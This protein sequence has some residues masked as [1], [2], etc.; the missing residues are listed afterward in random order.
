MGTGNANRGGGLDRPEAAQVTRLN[1]AQADEIAKSLDAMSMISIDIP[2]FESVRANYAKALTGAANAI[3]ILAKQRA[4]TP[5]ANEAYQA[6]GYQLE[7]NDET[8]EMR[9][10]LFQG[11]QKNVRS[12]LV[13]PSPDAYDMAHRVLKG[14][15]QLEGIK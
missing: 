14:Y 1:H 10:I 9:L 2:E 13:M 15:D 5:A 11:E 7:L 8:H 3:R 6:T 4:L 12:F